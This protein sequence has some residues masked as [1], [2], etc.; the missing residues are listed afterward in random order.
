VSP[1]PPEYSCMGG[2]HAGQEEAAS[3]LNIICVR[4]STGTELTAIVAIDGDVLLGEVAGEHPIA[5]SPHTERY[6]EQDLRLLHQGGYRVLVIARL[7]FP[8][9]GDPDAAEPDRE[10]VAIGRLPGLADRH[11]HTPPIG[12]FAGYCSLHQ[13]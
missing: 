4:S 2:C 5:S 3:G 7:A 13:G 1:L 11:H 8:F 10:A 6:L 9:V 12:V